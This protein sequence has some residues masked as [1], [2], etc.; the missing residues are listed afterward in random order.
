MKYVG[1]YGPVAAK[2]AVVG[3]YPGFAD[4]LEG[5][6][7]VGQ[8]GKLLNDYLKLAYQHCQL[9]YQ[10]PYKTNILKFSLPKGDWKQIGFLGV[11]L[12][13][14]ITKLK[15]ELGQFRPNVILALG[16][17]ALTA[18]TDKKGLCGARGSTKW[19]GSILTTIIRGQVTKVVPT[20]HPRQMLQESGPGAVPYSARSIWLLDLIRAIQESASPSLSLPSR[21]LEVANDSLDVY[22]FLKKY[23]DKTRVSIDIEVYHCVPTCIGLAFNS[24]HAMSIPLIDTISYTNEAGIS[25]KERR[26]IFKLLDQFFKTP[27]LEIIG[28][29]FKFDHE[30]L[31]RPLGFAVPSDIFVDTMLLAHTIQPE[32]RVS[33]ANLTRIYTREPYYKD[34]YKEFNPK[35]DKIEQVFLYNAKDAVVTYEIA[36]ELIKEAIEEGLWDFY[37]NYVRHLH[38]LYMEIESVGLLVD[39]TQRKA[40]NQ[41]YTALIEAGSEKF[42]ELLGKSVNVSSP[43]Q[44][45]GVIIDLGLPVRDGVDEDTLVALQANHCGNNP[46]ASAVIDNILNVRRYRKTKSTYIEADPDYDG[47]MRT[48]YRIVGT[49]TGRTSTSVM[50]S[51]LRPTQVGLAFQTMTK[52]GDIGGDVRTMFVADPGYNFLEVDL[53]QAEAR[54]VALLADD[55]ETL[56]MFDTGDIHRLTASWI[57]HKK[58]EDIDKNTERFIGKVCRHAGNY[59][60]RKRRHMLTVN[61]DIKRFKIPMS[62]LSEAQAGKN[63][64]IFHANAPKIQGVFQEEVRK[65]IQN[66]RQLINPFGR[67]RQFYGR[68]DESLFQEA[69]AQ[70]PQSTVPDQLRHAFL[71]IRMRLPEIRLCLESHDSGLYLVPEGDESRVGRILLEEVSTPI[72][73]SRCSIPRGSLVIPGEL[74]LGKNYKEMRS[75]IP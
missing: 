24:Q 18:L 39:Q 64:E 26:E 14:S 25:L 50:S 15:D 51:P 28:Q 54:I 32:F 53:S 4:T 12:E 55:L 71:R 47:R 22:R 23:K 35:K 5:K 72:D 59:G 62:P 27:N 21:N 42:Q 48:S 75:F 44:I 66:T 11:G 10:E 29:N 46:T 7:F 34:E 30:K 63:L 49:E 41:K 70:I 56:K 6:P 45:H 9:P 52:H 57:F 38:R 43:K 8:P 3:D 36:E 13:E 17:Q 40:L 33:L 68:M 2:I 65:L 19:V 37:Y 16:D 67:R 61:S 58:P 20:W 74:Q 1:G 69:Y 31:L 73:F 60:M